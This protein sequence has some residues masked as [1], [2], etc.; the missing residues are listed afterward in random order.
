VTFFNYVFHTVGQVKPS[1]RCDLFQ[2]CTVFHRSVHSIYVTLYR[3]PVG[4]GG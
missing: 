2:L 4:G 1:T 3:V